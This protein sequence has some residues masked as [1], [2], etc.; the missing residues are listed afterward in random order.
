MGG[1]VGP[2]LRIAV[3]AAEGAT[4]GD[5][6]EGTAVGDPGVGV[7]TTEGEVVMATLRTL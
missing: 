5:T 7:A 3:G 1:T 6:V 2:T 4:E